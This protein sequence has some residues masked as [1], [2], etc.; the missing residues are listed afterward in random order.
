MY[1]GPEQEKLVLTA[2][3]V[4][5]VPAGLHHCPL[6]VVKITRPLLFIDVAL[7]GRYAQVGEQ[8]KK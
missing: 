3:T 2:P 8:A 5:H 7:T 4:I 1:M 6:K